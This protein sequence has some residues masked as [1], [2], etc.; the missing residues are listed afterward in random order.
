MVIHKCR[1]NSIRRLWQAQAEVRSRG[2]SNLLGTEPSAAIAEPAKVH[3]ETGR[4]ESQIELRPTSSPA[5]SLTCELPPHPK[6]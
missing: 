6:G 4:R 1:A 5:R 2:V 3:E